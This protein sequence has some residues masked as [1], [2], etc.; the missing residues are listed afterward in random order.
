MYQ[1]RTMVHLLVVQITKSSSLLKVAVGK[2]KNSPKTQ[3][4]AGIQQ[5]DHSDKRA[6]SKF[7]GSGIFLSPSSELA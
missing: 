5:I 3:Q 4:M 2:K 7:Q 1:P 6:P